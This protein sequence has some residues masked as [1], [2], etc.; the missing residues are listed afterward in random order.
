M[1]A[2]NVFVMT[3]GS[4]GRWFTAW[5]PP[6]VAKGHVALESSNHRPP[7]WLHG[8]PVPGIAFL[9]GEAYDG[10]TRL[11]RQLRSTQEIGPERRPR[12]LER[13]QAADQLVVRLAQHEPV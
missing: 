12:V 6:L 8:A 13:C 5:R 10:P 7:V 1:D 11:G 2:A 4:L 9:L 3:S